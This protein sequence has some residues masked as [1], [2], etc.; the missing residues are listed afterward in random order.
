MN[1]KPI[2]ISSIL[3][4]N[5]NVIDEAFTSQHIYKIG[6]DWLKCFC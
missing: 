6:F 1:K 4:Y 5:P 3:I 2:I